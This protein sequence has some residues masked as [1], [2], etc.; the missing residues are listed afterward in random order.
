MRE[1]LLLL[2]LLLPPPS[3]LFLMLLLGSPVSTITSTELLNNIF[4]PDCC[5]SNVEASFSDRGP[6]AGLP[7]TGT[8]S[9]GGGGCVIEDAGFVRRLSSPP[10]IITAN[11]PKSTQRSFSFSTRVL[12]IAKVVREQTSA[13]IFNC[14]AV[15]GPPEFI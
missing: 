12:K 4:L 1:L 13:M 15:N 2:L 9:G 3:F 11:A 8:G 6:G 10:L 14:G 7:G 5:I